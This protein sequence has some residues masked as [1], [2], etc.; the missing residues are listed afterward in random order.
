MVHGHIRLVKAVH[1]QHAEELP[2]RSRVGTQAHQ[3]IGHRIVQFP[4][5]PSQQ[6][7]ALALH[8]A[9]AG[10]D[11]WPL[12]GEQQ[13]GGF[14]DLPGMTA[15]RRRVG[16]HFDAGGILVLEHL[17]RAGDVLGN[18]D[19]H[20]TGPAGGSYIEGFLHDHRDIFRPLYHEAV[21]HDGAGNADHIGFLE[22]IFPYQVALHLP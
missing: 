22:R 14:L 11:D 4:G 7:A 19:H 15:L 18:I 2:I 13:L 9:A 10:V 8:H 6:F 17:V 5:E 3:R 20:R 16:A 1:A 12:G 21:F